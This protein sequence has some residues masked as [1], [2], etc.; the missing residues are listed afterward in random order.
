MGYHMFLRGAGRTL[1]IPVLPETL[2]V[3]SEGDNQTENVLH[4][5]EINILAQK[6]L[7]KIEWEAV[8]PA[9]SAPY[10][11]VG[12]P[13]APIDCIRLIQSWRDAMQPVQLMLVGA[14][15]DINLKMGIESFSYEERGGEPGDVYYSIELLEYKDYT[16]RRISILNGGRTVV[17][18][19][20]RPGTGSL[21]PGSRYTVAPGDTIWS[22]AQR[23]YGDGSLFQR[24]YNANQSVINSRNAAT[25]NPR[26][27][28]YSGQVLT[29][30]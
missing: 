23:A 9:H 10:V 27:T 1:E 29:I 24:I 8:F 18:A 7:G 30:P 11:T 14:N 20:G 6:K 16:P 22:I 3:E 2:A 15:L 25:G 17:L 19:P 21:T 28:L 12:S 13:P 5:G 26:Y 4:L